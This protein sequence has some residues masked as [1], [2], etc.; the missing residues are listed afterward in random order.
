M[1]DILRFDENKYTVKTCT[2]GEE[3]IRYRAFMDLP[4]CAHP[5]APVQRMNL[6]VPESYYEGEEIN[7]YTLQTA[8]ILMPNTVG[9]YMEGPA[10]GPGMA[11]KGNIPNAT[12]CGL[13]HGYVVACPGVRGRTTGK[14]STEFFEGAS[15]AITGEENGRMV[16]KAPAFIIDMKAAIRYLRYNKDLIP[17]DTEHIITNGTSAG[18]ALS[19]L[20]GATGN[21]P[22]YEPYLAE[23]GAL[24][25]R[26]DVF[27]ASCYCPIHNLE[28]ADA[29]YEWL[30][31][32]HND[33]HRTKKIK[34]ENG[35]QRIPVD[36]VMS[37]KLQ[38]ASKE[39]KALF[40]S[41]VNSLSLKDEQGQELLLDADGEGSFK[42]YVKSFVIRAAQKELD[43]HRIQKDLPTLSMPGSEIDDQDY[44]V[45]EDGKVVDLDW[46]SFVTKITRMKPAPAF[47]ALDLSCPEND[48]FGSEDVPARH[49]TEYSYTHSEVN[50]PMADTEL[51]RIM[52]PLNFIGS[53]GTAKHWRIRHGIFDRDTA[54]AIP[55]ILAATLQNKG[56]DVDFFAP[57]GLPHSGDYDPDELFAWIDGLCRS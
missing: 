38:E 27:A 3:T 30:F 9:G 20:A 28:H 51:I 48:E 15:G 42:E 39:L 53:D 49:F 21:C 55:V 19:A 7:G 43:T 41:Y 13:G 35:V 18:G 52:N 4:Y 2:I 36:G 56:Y 31:C 47:D 29:A 8:P 33:Y 6:Y 26:D 11:T 17:G 10:G 40:P 57:W 5:V 32:G 16:G 54:L 45:I 25:E 50:G 22:E 14:R 12:F 37:E 34:T 24:D 1:D 46:D 23:I 44:L